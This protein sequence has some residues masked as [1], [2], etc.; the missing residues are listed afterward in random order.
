MGPTC[1]FLSG[2]AVPLGCS[3]RGVFDCHSSGCQ[4]G[5]AAKVPNKHS[6]KEVLSLGPSP[7]SLRLAPPRPPSTPALVASGWVEVNCPGSCLSSYTEDLTRP[8]PG[9]DTETGPPR[10][11]GPPG[12]WQGREKEGRGWDVEV[13][14]Q[15][16]NSSWEAA[17]GFQ[18]GMSLGGPSCRPASCSPLRLWGPVLVGPYRPGAEIC[19]PLS[20]SRLPPLPLL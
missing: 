7:P 9:L 15:S 17:W 5:R 18:W 19:F 20:T 12:S 11:S 10:G 13:S 4:T 6:S 16:P 8:S 2:P 14:G 3:R 1:C